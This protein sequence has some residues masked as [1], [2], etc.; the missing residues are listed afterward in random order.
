MGERFLPV[1]CQYWS[2][3]KADFLFYV[4]VFGAPIFI[5]FLLIFSV[6]CRSPRPPP[7]PL[8]PHTMTILRYL[9]GE[10]QISHFHICINNSPPLP[11]PPLNLSW[12]NPEKPQIRVGLSEITVARNARNMKAVAGDVDIEG[13]LAI[14]HGKQMR[15]I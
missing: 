4:W 12:P 2:L 6:R 3:L 5:I 13:K 15:S 11:S 14:N 9:I 10:A 7:P 1:P 8:P